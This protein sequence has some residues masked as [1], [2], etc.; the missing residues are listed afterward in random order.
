LKFCCRNSDQAD[1]RLCQAV[2]RLHDLQ[3]YICLGL[4]YVQTH[5]D[6]VAGLVPGLVPATSIVA[7]QWLN[8]QGRR[9]ISAFTRVFDTLCRRRQLR[10]MP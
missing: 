5:R 3:P 7:P 2:S 10:G 9:D 1:T 6:C 4:A 8:F